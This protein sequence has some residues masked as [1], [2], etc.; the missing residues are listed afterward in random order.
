LSQESQEFLAEAQALFGRPARPSSQAR[1][2]AAAGKRRQRLNLSLAQYRN[3]LDKNPD[4]WLEIWNLW[5]QSQ[6]EGFFR[7][8][9]QL[10]ALGRIILEWAPF[11]PTRCLRILSLGAG[12]GYEAR[13]LAM[14]MI[15]VGLRAKGWELF[16]HGLELVPA[17]VATAQAG[18]YSR[19]SLLPLPLELTKRFFRP[20]AGGWRF[21]DQLA[22]FRFEARNPLRLVEP[23]ADF[24]GADVIVARGL[25]WDT[26]DA[27]IPGLVS[28][29]RPLFKEEC[30]LLTAPGEFWPGLADFSLEEREG[31]TYYRRAASRGSPKAKPA[32]RSPEARAPLAESQ[33]EPSIQSLRWAAEE[34][35]QDDPEAARELAVELIHEE[36]L[37]GYLRAES[38]SLVAQAEEALG[39]PLAGATVREVMGFLQSGDSNP[40]Q[41][42]KP[43]GSGST[44]KA[45]ASSSPEP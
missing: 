17:L 16:I 27:E 20:R 28:R 5:A 11:A 7:H 9:A 14:T 25:T 19:E 18:C 41:T 10:D 24:S 44:P 21:R 36:A 12:A 29:V 35:L 40:G 6:D 13:S 34:K 31:V 22:N 32:R 42:K 2:L 3:L 1:F 4:E 26:P 33:L 43:V 38:L 39:R 45:I 30:V 37:E 15:N 23:P 8:S